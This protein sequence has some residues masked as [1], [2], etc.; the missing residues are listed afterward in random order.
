MKG[1]RDGVRTNDDGVMA[2][3]MKGLTDEQIDAIAQY[4]SSL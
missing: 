2:A 1:F 4:L 3:T